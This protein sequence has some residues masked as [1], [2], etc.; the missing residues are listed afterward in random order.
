MGRASAAL[1]RLDST[2]QQTKDDLQEVLGA[3][4][5]ASAL[6]RQLL[7]VSRRQEI[8]PRPIDLGYVVC[9]MMRMLRRLVGKQIEVR[10]YHEPDVGA[11]QADP[12]QIEQILLNLVVNAR[13]AMPNGGRLTIETKADR[14]ED[15]AFVRPEGLAPHTYA[16][17]RV[18][19]T[20]VGIAPGVLSRV[21]EPFF[22]TK[23]RGTGTGLGLSTVHGIVKQSGGRVAVDSMPGIGTTFTVW[24]PV[25]V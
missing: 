24:L 20:G 21:F 6:T 8:H 15:G 18:T 10:E 23:E 1:A 22:T 7:A 16:V 9:D 3:A 5:L 11:V 25:V 13:D 4:T 14:I 19:D 12:T 2:N 17:I